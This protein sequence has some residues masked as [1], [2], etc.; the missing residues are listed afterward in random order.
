MRGCGRNFGMMCRICMEERYLV[1][2]TGKERH[3][4]R[5]LSKR[6]R[7]FKSRWSLNLFN[8]SLLYH[9]R[10]LA[11]NYNLPCPSPLST[12]SVLTIDMWIWSCFDEHMGARH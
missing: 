2:E 7:W 8:I 10:C 9:L 6:E 5:F 11:N 4:E 12:H 1:S 3:V